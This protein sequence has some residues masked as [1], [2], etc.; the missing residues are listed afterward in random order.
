MRLSIVT[1]LYRSSEY[2]EA[3]YRRISEEAQKITHAYEIIL[4]DDGSPDDSLRKAVN[5]ADRDS[6]VKVVELSRNFGHHKAIMTGLAQ[7]DGEYIFLIDSDLEEEPELL[8]AF[9]QTMQDS[10]GVDMV[11]GV[12]EVR[13]GGLFERWNGQLFYKLFNYF[14]EVKI[15]KNFLTVRLMKRY[16]VENLLRFTEK[17]FIFSIVNILNGFRVQE[18]TVA[19]L[20]ISPTT[21]TWRKKIRLLVD[22]VTSSTAKPL[23][24]VFNFG[25]GVTTFS[26]VFILYL[27]GRKLFYGIGVDGWTSVMVTVFFFGGVIILFLGIIGIYLSKIFVEVKNR[28]FSIIRHIYQ[29]EDV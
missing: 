25:I 7:A 5:I 19:K 1:T 15:P 3:F 4:V 14:S 29:K 24:M 2:I 12:Q 10:D 20:S 22:A 16:Y 17:E 11:Y 23:W 21:Y 13:K 8:G 6:R 18:K 27:V 26:I 9:W 28:P